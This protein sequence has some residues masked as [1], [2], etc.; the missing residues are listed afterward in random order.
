MSFIVRGNNEKLWQV[1][2]SLYDE[3][4]EELFPVLQKNVPKIAERFEE[5]FENRF[6]HVD[7]T[8]LLETEEGKKFFV[9]S[10][11]EGISKLKEKGNSHWHDPSGFEPFLKKVEELKQII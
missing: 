1:K 6:G 5:A 4:Y 11:E 3:M 10:V 7:L 2:N 9:N 8:G